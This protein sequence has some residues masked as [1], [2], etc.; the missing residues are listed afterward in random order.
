MKLD[1]LDCW[2]FK[3]T[4]VVSHAIDSFS[5]KGQNLDFISS[6][7]T[8]ERGDALSHSCRAFLSGKNHLFFCFS[9]LK[10][11]NSYLLPLPSGSITSLYL[12]LPLVV[13]FARCTQS[14]PKTNSAV[15]QLH[16]ASKFAL[17]L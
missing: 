13:H 11:K 17:L 6:C 4:A 14:A 1:K 2:F 8:E 3:P 15:L 9:L 7:A 5:M 10:Q 12:F 16:C